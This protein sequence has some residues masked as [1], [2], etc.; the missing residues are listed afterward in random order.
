MLGA[1]GYRFP[2]HFSAGAGGVLLI[3]ALTAVGFGCTHVRHTFLSG[4]FLAVTRTGLFLS[5]PCLVIDNRNS[6]GNSV[7]HHDTHPRRTRGFER[8]DLFREVY[9]HQGRLVFPQGS[10]WESLQAEGFVRKQPCPKVCSLL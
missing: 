5:D 9:R 10:L 4:D 1:G 8:R 7:L 3:S 2:L 6:S